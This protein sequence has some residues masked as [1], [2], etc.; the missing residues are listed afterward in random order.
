MKSERKGW[1]HK[2]ESKK[3]KKLISFMEETDEIYQT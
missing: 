3:T 2:K 1:G